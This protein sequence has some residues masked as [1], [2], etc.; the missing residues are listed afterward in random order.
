MYKSNPFHDKM[1]VNVTQ[2]KCV[3]RLHLVHKCS[4][5]REEDKYV[6]N[7]NQGYRD[8]GASSLG[9][10]FEDPPG[11]TRIK[12]AWLAAQRPWKA[13]VNGVVISGHGGI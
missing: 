3:H 8:D 11:A 6:S 1:F 2:E 7:L 4:S 5:I 9:V 12:Q 13:F 10:W